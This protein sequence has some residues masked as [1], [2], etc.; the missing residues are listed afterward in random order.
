MCYFTYNNRTLWLVVEVPVQSH[1][2]TVS[3]IFS[4]DSTKA[5]GM[6][7][8]V[9]HSRKKFNVRTKVISIQQKSCL[10]LVAAKDIQVGDELLYDYGE[11]SKEVTK[12]FPWLLD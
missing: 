11:R 8:M 12:T 3:S 2:T 9:N 10:I 5:E 1:H 4:I 7:R 6:G